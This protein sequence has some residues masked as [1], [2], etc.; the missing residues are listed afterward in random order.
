MQLQ[1]READHPLAAF[2]ESRPRYG[3]APS[4]SQAPS[5][6]QSP[7]SR[8]KSPSK[9]SIYHLLEASKSREGISLT[10]TPDSC[11]KSQHPRSR[12]GVNPPALSTVHNNSQQSQQF[13]LLAFLVCPS[14]MS[15]ALQ[16]DYSI[17]FRCDTGHKLSRCG[18][19]IQM[20]EVRIRW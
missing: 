7:D 20:L 9:C 17:Y 4:R 3:D 6:C 16:R 11:R 18:C 14:P 13:L 15:T 10:A 19:R 8:L 12:R 5:S 1:E 2:P